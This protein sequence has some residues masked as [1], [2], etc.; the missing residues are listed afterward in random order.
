M[1]C[2]A[3]FAFCDNAVRRQGTKLKIC[4]LVHFPDKLEGEPML[5]LGHFIH[6]SHDE[7]IYQISLRH[8]GMYLVAFTCEYVLMALFLSCVGSTPSRARL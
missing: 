5:V 8:V 2:M 4:G 7:G 1:A 3:Q 6:S